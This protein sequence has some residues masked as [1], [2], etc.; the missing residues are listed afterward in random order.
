MKKLM[1]I[2]AVLLLAGCEYAR[3]A[4]GDII[5]GVR[6]GSMPETAT[7]F[8]GTAINAF[9]PGLGTAVAG[10]LGSLVAGGAGVGAV[11]SSRNKNTERRRKE[12]DQAREKMALENAAIKALFERFSPAER[13]EPIADG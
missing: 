7:E 10:V 12:A 8:V 11:S 1:I 4:S 9:V 2:P 13:E 3:N 6:L 5:M